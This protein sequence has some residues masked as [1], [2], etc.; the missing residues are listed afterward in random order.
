MI[1]VLIVIGTFLG[2]PIFKTQLV[3]ASVCDMVGHR[4]A[5]RLALREGVGEAHWRCVNVNVEDVPGR[6]A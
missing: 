2:Q 6:D 4:E 5:E 3:P 1:A